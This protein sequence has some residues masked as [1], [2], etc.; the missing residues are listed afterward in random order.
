VFVG[1]HAPMQGS[2][3]PS[4]GDGIQVRGLLRALDAID[5]EHG[6]A[7]SKSCQLFQTQYRLR[8]K[9]AF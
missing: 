8:R 4:N 3:F 7:V 5:A 2:P 1:S 9:A 6:Q